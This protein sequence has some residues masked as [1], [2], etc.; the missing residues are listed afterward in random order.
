MCDFLTGAFYN[1]N[2]FAIQHNFLAVHVISFFVWPMIVLYIVPEDGDDFDHPNMFEVKSSD[3][4]ITLSKF[5]DFFPLK[6]SFHF[7]FL[8]VIGKN[9]VWLD[10]VDPLCFVPVY[11]DGSIFSKISRIEIRSDIKD[12]AQAH[13]VAPIPQISSES[14]TRRNSEKLL[15]FDDYDSSGTLAHVPSVSSVFADDLLGISSTSTAP[16]NVPS[17]DIASKKTSSNIDLFALDTLQPSNSVPLNPMMMGTVPTFNSMSQTP[18]QRQVMSNSMSMPQIAVTGT[19]NA[20]DAFSTLAS[21]Y[22]GNSTIRP[23]GY[24]RGP[25]NTNPRKPI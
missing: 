22:G 7:R 13:H 14:S 15:K 16:D 19:G 10:C 20:F 2:N 5:M 12:S 8:T 23:T 24:P 18:M 9:N 6:G 1:N 25:P 17:A 4:Q 21:S 3:E 11:T